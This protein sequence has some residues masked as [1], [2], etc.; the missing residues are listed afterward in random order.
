MKIHKNNIHKKENTTQNI[1][2]STEKENTPKKENTQKRRLYKK[3]K[4]HKNN[5][6]TYKRK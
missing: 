3:T 4:I 5:K 6:N 1:Q 2:K